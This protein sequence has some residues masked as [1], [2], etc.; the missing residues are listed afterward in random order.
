[1]LLYK[2]AHGLTF[3]HAPCSGQVGSYIIHQ[4]LFVAFSTFF[5]LAHYYNWLPQYR[6]QKGAGKFNVGLFKVR[7]PQCRKVGARLLT[8]R[9][10]MLILHC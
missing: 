1:M 6:I 7:L 8:W 9:G 10:R 3:R 2:A 4:T 5:C